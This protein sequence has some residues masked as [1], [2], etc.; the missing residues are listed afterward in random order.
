MFS[1]V[2][3]SKKHL[4]MDPLSAFFCP[5]LILKG[6][7]AF[8]QQHFHEAFKLCKILREKIIAAVEN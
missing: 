6:T 7:Y 5:I 1:T 3:R 2:L 4:Q 8:H